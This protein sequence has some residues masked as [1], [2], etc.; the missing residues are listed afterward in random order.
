MHLN[1]I[2]FL[3]QKGLF[4]LLWSHVHVLILLLEPTKA[5]LDLIARL[6]TWLL[7]IIGYRCDTHMIGLAAIVGVSYAVCIQTMVICHTTLVVAP[8][9][10]Y[11]SSC[12]ASLTT[13]VMLIWLVEPLLWECLVHS[14]TK[15]RE[16]ATCV[17]A[18]L[19][20]YYVCSSGIAHYKYHNFM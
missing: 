6:D 12:Y 18:S 20:S 3:R 16:P 9:S 13:I 8:I 2:R 11:V 19:S 15:Q 5:A 10:S 17:V 7:C 14:A 4:A 1:T